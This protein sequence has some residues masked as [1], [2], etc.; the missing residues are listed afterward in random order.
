MD[1][2]IVSSH[3]KTDPWAEI[4]IRKYYILNLNPWFLCSYW[5]VLAFEFLIARYLNLYKSTIFTCVNSHCLECTHTAWWRQI[6]CL[7]AYLCCPTWGFVFQFWLIVYEYDS[8]FQTLS[9]AALRNK[10]KTLHYSAKQPQIHFETFMA[11][12]QNMHHIFLWL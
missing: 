1:L 6:S 10:Q 9:F 12:V 11:S 2:F 4:D 5:A 8:F 7:A 3:C